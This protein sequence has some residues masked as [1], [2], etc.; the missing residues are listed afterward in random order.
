MVRNGRY[1]E[2]RM[3]CPKRRRRSICKCDSKLKSVQLNVGEDSKDFIIY[4]LRGGNFQHQ[5][6]HSRDS[7]NWEDG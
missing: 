2:Q 4:I 6:S 3:T 5:G 7:S 1:Q